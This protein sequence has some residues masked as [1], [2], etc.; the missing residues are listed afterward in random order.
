MKHDRNALDHARDQ[1][2]LQ[3]LAMS[4]AGKTSGQISKRYSIPSSQIRTVL[5]RIKAD[6]DR[7]EAE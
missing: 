3:W 6:T 1:M 2:H 5:N 4:D 7:S